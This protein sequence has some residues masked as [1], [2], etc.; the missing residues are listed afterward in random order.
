MS[1][2]QEVTSNY[3]C[4]QVIASNRLITFKIKQ[5]TNYSTMKLKLLN[6]SY[7]NFLFSAHKNTQ[8]DLEDEFLDDMAEDSDG[9]ESDGSESSGDDLGIA[10]DPE[11]SGKK[12]ESEE[13]SYE[14]LTPERIMQHMCDIIRD[15]NNVLQVNDRTR[16]TG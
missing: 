2:A 11:S 9:R 6:E 7:A 14:V 4:N 1:A 10:M 15:V 16:F 5:L 13:F 8:M 3:H 12:R